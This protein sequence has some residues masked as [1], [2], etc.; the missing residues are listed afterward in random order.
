MSFKTSESIKELAAALA[1]AQGEIGHANKDRLNPAFKA[2]YAD[3]ASV[4]DACRDALA[5]N[6][7][8]VMQPVSVAP[9]IVSVTTRIVHA[10][11]EWAEC[12]IDIAPADMRAHAIGS[13]IT[14]GRRYGLSSMVGVAPDDDDG[15]AA[16][17][18]AKQWPDDVANALAAI[19]RDFPERHAEALTAAATGGIVVLRKI[20]ADA[21]A[22]SKPV[23]TMRLEA[24]TS[25]KAET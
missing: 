6:S 11:G 1:K 23:V 2:R 19:G 15:N 5:T 10:S 14:Y 7:L 13:A 8:A 24:P 17:S 12:T 9:G 16:S 21:K 25:E 20:Y 4:L 22:L 18:H 3:L